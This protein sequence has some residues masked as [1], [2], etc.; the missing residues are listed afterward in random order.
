LVNGPVQLFVPVYV[1]T[2]VELV[3]PLAVPAIVTLQ[4]GNPEIP[5]VGTVMVNVKVVPASVPST[6]PRN[7]TVPSGVVAVTE[8][9]TEVPDCETAVHVTFP[10]PVESD[11]DPE[12]APLRLTVGG[13]G[14]VGGLLGLGSLPHDITLR[15]NAT[16]AVARRNAAKSIVS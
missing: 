11:A 6:L 14:A 9:D 8:P 16:T 13:V 2:I 15:A 1:P 4:F 12:Y 7:A 10:D 3:T 5:P